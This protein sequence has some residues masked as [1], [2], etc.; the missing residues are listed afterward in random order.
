MIDRK[1]IHHKLNKMPYSGSYQGM[2]Y[3]LSAQEN[4]ISVYV[5]PE[6]FNLEKTPDELKIHQQFPFDDDGLEQA[7]DWLDAMYQEREDYWQEAKKNK[8]R[9][10]D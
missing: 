7:A 4:T 2:R 10:P 6:P 3:H 8:F 1:L 9:M 5:Y